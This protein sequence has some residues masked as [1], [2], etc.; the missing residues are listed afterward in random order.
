MT[1]AVVNSRV[2]VGEGAG[3]K[4]QSDGSFGGVGEVGKPSGTWSDQR[5]S[6]GNRAIA[7]V[8][9]EGERGCVGSE[10][11]EVAVVGRCGCGNHRGSECVVEQNPPV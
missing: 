3:R 5:S 4:G 10:R 2:G 9:E 7:W 11:S 6:N 8:Q 1:R